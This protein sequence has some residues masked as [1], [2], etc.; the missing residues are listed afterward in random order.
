MSNT[1]YDRKEILQTLVISTEKLKTLFNTIDTY[2]EI[3]EMTIED[4]DIGIDYGLDMVLY[5][6]IVKIETDHPSLFELG[7]IIKD[8][9][10]VFDSSFG[11]VSFDLFGK[12]KKPR[13]NYVKYAGNLINEMSMNLDGVI[14]LDVHCNFMI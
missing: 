10:N 13:D 5:R 11:K 6:V 4:Y 9:E 2:Y 3:S 8:L 12:L 14:K 7:N 1:V